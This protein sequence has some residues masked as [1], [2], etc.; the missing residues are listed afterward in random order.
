[1]VVFIQG[2]RLGFIDRIDQNLKI[3]EQ[4]TCDVA[5]NQH[6]DGSYYISGAPGGYAAVSVYKGPKP[7]KF[8]ERRETSKVSAEES[9]KVQIFQLLEDPSGSGAYTSGLAVIQMSPMIRAD[10]A[11]ASMVGEFCR[12]RNQD[13]Y[14]CGVNLAGVDL[15]YLLMPGD[16]FNGNLNMLEVK[17]Q[18]AQYE[19]K[20]GYF[21]RFE[22]VEY[23]IPELSSMHAKMKKR[24]LDWE[25]LEAV[26]LRKVPPRVETIPA[27]MAV[28]RLN[29]LEPA[30]SKETLKTMFSFCCICWNLQRAKKL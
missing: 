14:Y 4:V 29:F 15:S 7:I 9:H 30:V 16:C 5:W 8:E 11:S 3:G 19:V 6:E 26:L 23:P 17:E 22:R 20:V 28:G 25:T 2:K 21:G 12:F 27:G 10:C 18:R 13:L 1:M 24:F